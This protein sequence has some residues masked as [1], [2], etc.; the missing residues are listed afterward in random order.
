MSETQQLEAYLHGTLSPGEQLLLEARLLI[1]T[2]LKEKT[3]WQKHTYTLINFYGRQ[4]L[5]KEIEVV[6][7]QLFTEK[8]FENF[9]KKIADVFK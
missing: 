8:R 9:R 7:K 2:D 5:K 4:Q 3:F 6:Q 1:D